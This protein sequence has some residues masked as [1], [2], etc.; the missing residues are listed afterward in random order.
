MLANA[1][2]TFECRSQSSSARGRFTINHEA[3]LELF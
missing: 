2:A 3:L 1:G